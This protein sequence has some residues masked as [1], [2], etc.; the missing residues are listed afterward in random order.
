MEIEVFGDRLEQLWGLRA[1][2]QAG[3]GLERIA[4]R[5]AKGKLTAWERGISPRRLGSYGAHTIIKGTASCSV[6]F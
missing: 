5:R 4:Q 6:R 2:A 3:K 1:G